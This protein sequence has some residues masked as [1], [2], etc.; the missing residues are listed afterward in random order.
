M[1]R[2]INDIGIILRR[3]PFLESDLLLTVFSKNNGKI[4]ILTK[5]SRKIKSK[6]MGHFEPFC[7]VKF[8]CL[9]GKSFFIMTSL[10]TLDSHSVTKENSDNIKIYSYI[11]EVV[12]ALTPEL[13]RNEELFLSIKKY[14]NTNNISE[15]SIAQ[16]LFDI[17]KSSGF[18]PNISGCSKCGN[19]NEVLNH[20]SFYWGGL[21]CS[22]CGISSSAKRIS[23]NTV[24]SFKE[25]TKNG[26][27]KSNN[28]NEIKQILKAFIE[29]INENKIKTSKYI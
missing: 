28:V 14:L 20:F 7:L 5:G 26:N 3:R 21:V 2:N 12:D 24:S 6:F 19:I 17:L 27:I 4:V 29:Y 23:L 8:S 11:S 10:E 15:S 22:K 18:A 16:F 1:N 9:R 13:E 25:A